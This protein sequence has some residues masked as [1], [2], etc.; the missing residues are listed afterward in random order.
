MAQRGDLSRLEDTEPAFQ[1][2]EGGGLDALEGEHDE[3]HRNRR[4][5]E[6]CERRRVGRGND[7]RMEGQRE[8]R[9]PSQVGPGLV[10]RPVPEEMDQGGVDALEQPVETQLHWLALFVALVLMPPPTAR[11]ANI[12]GGRLD[13]EDDGTA[14]AHD[15][16]VKHPDLPGKGQEDSGQAAA[17]ASQDQYPPPPPPCHLPHIINSFV[18][19]VA[20]VGTFKL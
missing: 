18:T 8:E 3:G 9:N 19:H 1:R 14:E 17:S 5:E 2:G 7:E 16:D 13:E 12:G 6:A 11:G 20:H 4:G 10:F 15:C